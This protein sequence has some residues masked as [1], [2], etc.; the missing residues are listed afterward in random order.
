MRKDVRQDWSLRPL[1]HTFHYL[2]PQK[3]VSNRAVWIHSLNFDLGQ[4]FSLK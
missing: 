3:T 2:H 1:V 4:T